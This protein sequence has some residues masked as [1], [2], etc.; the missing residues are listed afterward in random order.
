[1]LYK[2]ST[3]ASFANNIT[4][5]ANGQIGSG[6][7]AIQYKV[8]SLVEDIVY[9]PAATT[10]GVLRFPTPS[11]AQRRCRAEGPGLSSPTNY[12]VNGAYS[13]STTAYT[14]AECSGH[15]SC[16]EA[17]LCVCD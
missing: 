6:M 8:N 14:S 4:F 15:G 7:L 9:P 16:T 17:G 12:G 5:D 10:S 1:M 13:G 11:W 2:T 3:S